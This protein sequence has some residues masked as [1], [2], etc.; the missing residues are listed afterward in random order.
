V[1]CGRTSF[2]VLHHELS[3][4]TAHFTGSYLRPRAKAARSVEQLLPGVGDV[5]FLIQSSQ[6]RVRP[7]GQIAQTMFRSK[8]LNARHKA[9][10]LLIPAP[11][12][13]STGRGTPLPPLPT[14]LRAGLRC[15]GKLTQQLVY[16]PL[17]GLVR[18]K[19]KHDVLFQPP[20]TYQRSSPK[21]KKTLEHE[22][23]SEQYYKRKRRFQ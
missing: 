1:L 5:R 17:S 13:R 18:G 20:G 2:Q 4:I 15:E 8:T 7:T 16:V 3:A 14:D 19:L 22:G 10:T 9:S 12:A 21:G 11:C 6:V 23:F